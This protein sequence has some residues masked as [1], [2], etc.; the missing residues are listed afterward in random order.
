MH[1]HRR[2]HLCQQPSELLCDLLCLLSRETSWRIRL[3]YVHIIC[4][5]CCGLFDVWHSPG[6]TRGA[7]MHTVRVRPRIVIDV[8][9]P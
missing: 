3:L 8:G 6:Q 9:R 1:S 2:C 7:G 4:E 5:A